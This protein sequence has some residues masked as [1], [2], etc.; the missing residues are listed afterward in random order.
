MMIPLH[1][2]QNN[3]KQKENSLKGYGETRTLI[4]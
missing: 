1:T 3:Y 2:H 4:Y